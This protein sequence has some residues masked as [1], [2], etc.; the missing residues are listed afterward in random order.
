MLK[1]HFFAAKSAPERPGLA[2]TAAAIGGRIGTEP[3]A[4]NSSARPGEAPSHPAAAGAA[5]A[6]TQVPTAR[7]GVEKKNYLKKFFCV[8]NYN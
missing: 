4:A 1:S 7:K 8:K 2:T 5:T 3:T 6:R